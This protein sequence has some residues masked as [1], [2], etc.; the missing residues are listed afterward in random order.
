[1]T[2]LLV[3]LIAF[4]LLGSLVSVDALA[5][6]RHG[7]PPGRPGPGPA[8][9]AH[10]RPPAPAARHSGP[11]SRATRHHPAARPA[12]R[13][14]HHTPA[15]PPKSAHRPFT[16]GWYAARPHL[17][18]VTRPRADVVSVATVAGVTRWLAVPY[19]A[20]T[21]VVVG[22]QT[23]FGQSTETVEADG[24]RDSQWMTLGT[25]ALKPA[26][27]AAATR[28]IQLEVDH[29]G[30]VRGA[31][32][33]LLSEAVHEIEGDIDGQSMTVSWQIGQQSGI[34]FETPLGELTKPEGMVTAHFPDGNTA[35]WQTI[36]IGQ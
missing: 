32:S 1:M 27:K 22:G 30:T 23:E 9:R 21:P 8:P 29:E 14:P 31:H 3:G 11:A 19:A 4:W 5:L 34:H 36:Q 35:Q 26:G 2:R 7:G 6:G 13:P 12:H 10:H 20:T 24:P 17:R 25:F 16:R 15:T 33:D 28:L 18:H